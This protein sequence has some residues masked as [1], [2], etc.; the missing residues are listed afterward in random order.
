MRLFVT[1]KGRPAIV[2]GYG[3][4]KTGPKAMVIGLGDGIDA[5]NPGD[6]ILPRMPKRLRRKIASFVKQETKDLQNDLSGPH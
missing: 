4:G 5:V 2:V 3:P 1:V 6:C